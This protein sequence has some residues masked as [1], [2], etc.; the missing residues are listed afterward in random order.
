MAEGYGTDFWGRPKVSP[1]W[2]QDMGDAGQGLFAD[3]NSAVQVATMPQPIIAADAGSRE[4]ERQARGGFM[5]QFIEGM[6]GEVKN[7]DNALGN[8][9]SG[10]A[11]FLWW[12]VDKV[13]SA[14]YWLYSEAVAQPTATLML[15]L[16][17]TDVP[18]DQGGGLGVLMSGDEWSDA[19]GKAEHVSPGQAFVNWANVTTSQHGEDLWGPSKVFFGA[20]GAGGYA[21]TPQEQENIKRNTERFLYDSEYWRDKSEWSYTIGSGGLDAMLNLGADPAGAIVAGTAKVVKG[22]RSIQLAEAAEQPARG[23]PLER[24]GEAV[25]KRLAPAP[26]KVEEAVKADRVSKFFDWAEGKSAAEIA[27]HP[28]WGRGRRI[29]PESYKI[30][31]VLSNAKRDDMPLM[32]R[33]AGGDNAAAAE[34]ATQS[35]DLAIQLSKVQEHRA[36]VDSIRFDEDLLQ[37]FVKEQQAGQAPF[38]AGLAPETSE[39]YAKVSEH[40]ITSRIRPLGPL[41]GAPKANML[42]AKKWRAAQL[43]L[44]NKQVES[45][46]GTNEFYGSVLGDSLG[47][48]IEDFSPGEANIFGTMKSMYRTGPMALR[49]SEKTAEMKIGRMIGQAPTSKNGMVATQLIRN[50]FYSPAVQVVRWLGDKMPEQFIDHN[51]DDAFE[52]VAEMLRRVP[53]M[54]PQQRLDMVNAYSQAGDKVARSQALEEIHTSIVEHIAGRVGGL[55]PETARVIDEMRKVGFA[56]TMMKLGGSPP[57]GQAFSG[58]T[59]PLTGK[60][61]DLMEDGEAYIMAS[62]QIQN[63]EPL[64]PVVEFTRLLKRNSGF[65]RKQKQMGGKAADNVSMVADSLNTVWK[66]ATLLRPG[67]VLR[68]MS[69]EQVA[70]VVKFGMI[71]SI[72]HLAE[73]GKN[74][75]LNRGQHIKAVVGAGSYA[76]TVPGKAQKAIVKIGDP[77]VIAATEQR[78]AALKAE[79]SATKDP[80]RIA[81][82]KRELAGAKVQRVRISDAWPVTQARITS[83]RNALEELGAEIDKM[84]ADPK[85]DPVVLNGL[86]DKSLDHQTVLD[87]HVDY[88]KALLQEAKDAQGRRLGEDELEWEGVRVPQAFSPEWPHPIPRDQITSGR[89]METLF[90][91]GEA[92][93]NGRIIKTGSWKVITPDEPQH[94]QSWLD[95]LNKQFRQDELFRL[96]ASDPT[97]KAAK[98]WLKT[99]AGKAHM[100]KLGERAR[101]YSGT[102]RAIE[103]TLDKYLPPATGLRDKLAKGEEINEAELR[104][105][106]HED[107]FPSVHGE[108]LKAL[109]AMFSKQT[110]A[111]V[112]DDTI[113]KA[114]NFLGTVPNDIMARQPIYLRAQE[115][116]MRELISQEISYRKSVGVTDDIP[117]ETLNKMLHKSDRLARKDISQVV[118][119]PTRTTATEAL[120]FVAPFLSAHVDGLQRWAGLIAERPQFLGTAAKIY[121]APVAAN[122]VTDDKGRPVDQRGY[123]KVENPETGELEEKFIPLEERVLTLRMPE[124]TTN[125]KGVGEVRTGGVPIK[126][127][128]LNTILPGDPWFHPGSGPFVQMSASAIAKAHPK[129]GDFLQWAKVLPYG[130]SENV[131]D[132]LLPKY[133]KDAWDAFTT[134]DPDN[135][136]YQSAYLAEYQRQMGEYANGGDA[137]DMK[138]VEENAKSFMF[139]EAFTAWASPAQTKETP[140]TKSPYQFFVDQ[141]KVMQEV[142][143]ENARDKFLQRYGKDYFVFTASMSKSMGIAAT[144]SADETAEKFGDLI[145]RD[146]SMASLVVGDINNKGEFSSSVYRKQMEQLV[147]GE[148]VRQKLTAAEAIRENQKSLGWEKYNKYMGMLDAALIRSGFTSYGQKGTEELQE[149]KSQIIDIIGSN[150][151]AWAEDFGEVQINKI[152][153]RIKA[154]ERITSDEKLMSDPLR[155]DL[156]VLRLY[157]GARAQLKAELTKRGAKRLSFGVETEV[158]GQT[159]GGEPMGENEDIGQSLRQLQLY[160]VNMDTRFG[161]VFHRYLDQDDLS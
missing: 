27:Q 116:R 54:N 124:E 79:I 31:E 9:P 141:Y 140:L 6:V 61:V 71:S 88:A 46:R 34:L 143:P 136:A 55:D 13:A 95:G 94:M 2:N 104:A 29:G 145:E 102:L 132:P 89:G 158:E 142:D 76:P 80:K 115:A 1:W 12:P 69:E 7:V 41:G 123:A 52:R 19:Y 120:R 24:L 138:L 73:G 160:F 36:L 11:S 51:A 45:L 33:I 30:S 149:I 48:G 121:N 18:T 122:L 17:K 28:I 87:E 119:D 50:G 81:D 147:G 93:D 108:E 8:V 105:A 139:L 66:A 135:T 146:P 109:T 40:I 91:R 125:V 127:S 112:V 23:L 152:P 155:S 42:K 99:P 35:E 161:D 137:P 20:Y 90:A 21:A 107:D 150:N 130:P 98:D 103:V 156:Q 67:Y 117:P 157:L 3:P 111:R 83:E 53:G 63:A 65:L 113:A 47:K 25:G 101:D 22:A 96:V 134:N 68:S 58:A 133:M 129:T 56:K 62:T 14:A 159:I 70:S 72:M 106:I 43:D 92:I 78:A 59:D 5:Q 57:P 154:M 44:V 110:A 86:I 60:R 39:L 114:F 128:A 144:V 85:S 26:L 77:A 100:M 64:L 49:S 75:A 10:L 148:R 151:E 153:L 38:V 118:Y 126:M 131:Y 37:H 84:M 74:W 97:M 4:E 32:L 15:Q 16:A 82:L